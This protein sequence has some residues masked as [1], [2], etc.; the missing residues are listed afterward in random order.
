[1]LSGLG[2]FHPGIKTQTTTTSDNN[3]VGV[4]VRGVLRRTLLASQALSAETKT[5]SLTTAKMPTRVKSMVM[6]VVTDRFMTGR[7]DLRS[8]TGLRACSRAG[9]SGREQFNMTQL[10]RAI[11]ESKC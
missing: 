1:M 3:I 5:A 6:L 10:D 9:R 2:P 11:R 7:M 8:K 4:N